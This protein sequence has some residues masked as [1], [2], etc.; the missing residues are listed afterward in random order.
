MVHTSELRYHDDDSTLSFD[1]Y[2]FLTT[3]V[4][5]EMHV[6]LVLAPAGDHENVAVS[7]RPHVQVQSLGPF[8]DAC[9]QLISSQQ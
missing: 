2:L 3:L 9:M 6:V 5:N 1:N 8:P 4:P 7:L